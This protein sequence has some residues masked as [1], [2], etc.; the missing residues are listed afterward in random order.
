MSYAKLCDLVDVREGWYVGLTVGDGELNADKAVIR[1]NLKEILFRKDGR[2]Y[3]STIE[4][5]LDQAADELIV[6]LDLF[7]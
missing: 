4:T 6:Q 2:V 5:T 7:G 3:V 1:R